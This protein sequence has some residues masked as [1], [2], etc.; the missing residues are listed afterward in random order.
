MAKRA[1]EDRNIADR[2][3]IAHGNFADLDKIIRNHDFANISGIVADLGLSSFHLDESGRG[4]SFQKH[5]PL[6]MRFDISGSAADS[7]DARFLL[8]NRSVEEL[9]EI[10]KKYGEEPASYLIAKAIVR[11]RRDKLYHYTTD[12][13]ETIQQAL[14][15][16]KQHQWTNSARRIFQA[17]RIE[18][19]HELDNLESFLPKALDLLNPGGRLAVVTFHSLEDRIVKQFFVSAN[20]GCICPLDFPECRCG[21][22]PQAKI[23]TKKPVV[24]GAEELAGNSRS[25]SAKLRA[26]IKL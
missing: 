16:P 14:P 15:K 8:N 11:Q 19:N 25:Q 6:D 13:V 10:F 12:L 22:T 20:A 3:I 7:A 4:L 17:L 1:A 9:A 5:E 18:V 2:V 21:R 23:L 24:P 26:V